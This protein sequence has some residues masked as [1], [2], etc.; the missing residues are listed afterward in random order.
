MTWTGF[1]SGFPGL[2]LLRDALP[3][4]LGQIGQGGGGKTAEHGLLRSIELRAEHGVHIAADRTLGARM[5]VHAKDAHIVL[6]CVENVQKRYLCRV[7]CEPS[8][9]DARFHG[10]ESGSLEL[11]QDVADDDGVHADAS[12]EER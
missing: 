8:P 4:G 10:N 6:H 2:I 9:S 7:L 3:R 5:L 12:R 11:A 1:E